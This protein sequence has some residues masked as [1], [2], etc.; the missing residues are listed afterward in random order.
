MEKEYIARKKIPDSPGV[1]FFLGPRKEIL[2]I[3]KATSLGS[4]VRSYFASDIEEKR[5]PLIKDMLEA[6]QTIEWTVT[7][8]VLEAL[9]L[10][11]NLIRTHTNQSTILEQKMIRVLTIS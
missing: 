6:A 4:R 7:D 10:E 2:Y 1:Y 9:I 8:S 5:S 3:G 11:A